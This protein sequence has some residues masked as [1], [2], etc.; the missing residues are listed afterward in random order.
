MKIENT[1]NMKILVSQPFLNQFSKF[2]NPW[3]AAQQYN[4][5]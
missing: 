5:Y 3:K 1:L 4:L 2:K